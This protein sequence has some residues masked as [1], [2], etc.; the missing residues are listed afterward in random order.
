MK[1]REFTDWPL[2]DVEEVAR[3]LYALRPIKPE[4]REEYRWKSL[5]REAC[6]FLDN[7]RAACQAVLKERK[8]RGEIYA[9]ANLRNAEADKLPEQI[10]FEKAVRYITGETRTDRALPKLKKVLRYNARSAGQKE[11]IEKMLDAKLVEWRER[12][13]PRNEAMELQAVCEHEWPRV[14]AEQN[15]ARRK[16]S[17]TSR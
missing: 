12:G 9:R 8:E 1:L 4:S 15:K 13:I 16:N 6:D 10:P 3:M 5:A 2:A 17:K 11:I 14:K 7:C